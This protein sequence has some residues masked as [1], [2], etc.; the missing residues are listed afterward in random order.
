MPRT[1]RTVAGRPVM[2]TGAASGIGRSLAQ[3]LSRRGSPVAIADID[4]TGL[5]ETAHSLT[6]SVLTRILDVRDADDQR[7]FAD[8]VRDWLPA[9][10][11][12]V[13]NNA[14]VAVSSS[15]LTAVPDDDEWLRRINFDGVVNG[16]RA[17]LPILVEQ[18][19]GV[20]VNTSSVFGLL[21][22]P[23]QS[24]YCAA[25][26]A[27]RGF[28][29]ALRQELRGTGVSAVNVHPGGITTNIARNARVHEDPE[30]RGRTHEEMA[31]EFEAIT[32]TSPGKAADIIVRG[33]E[34]GKARILVGPD[35][36]VFDGLARIAPTRYYDV[37]ALVEKRLR[38]RAKTGATR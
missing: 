31:A 23:Y 10:L 12:A 37:I 7:R 11:A 5:K 26:F 14:G 25:K 8:E 2:I 18:D 33:V 4:E 34:R 19:D 32:M 30:G 3:N 20:V 13:F 17:F 15:V 38:A 28:T 16:T 9:P 21:G 27:V 24:A 1:R 36:Y 29:D 35:A 6:G 22:M